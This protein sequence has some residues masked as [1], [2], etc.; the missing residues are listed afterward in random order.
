M[1]LC[2]LKYC[3]DHVTRL[4]PADDGDDAEGDAAG[5]ADNAEVAADAGDWGVEMGGDKSK[6]IQ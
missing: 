3:H 4:G 5:A 6:L 1:S 2:G